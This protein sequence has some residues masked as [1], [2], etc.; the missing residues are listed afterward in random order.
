MGF[1]SR[2]FEIWG[3]EDNPQNYSNKA[4]DLHTN[5][6][7]FSLLSK[8]IN[9]AYNK[10][11]ISPLGYELWQYLGVLLNTNSTYNVAFS[12]MDQKHRQFPH[13]LVVHLGS[14][15]AKLNIDS[16]MI[17]AG[18]EE[19]LIQCKKSAFI[20]PLNDVTAYAEYL[21]MSYPNAKEFHVTRKPLDLH[22]LAWTFETNT[23]HKVVRQFVALM[24]MGTYHKIVEIEYRN[25]FKKD[26]KL[27]KTIAKK[28][29]PEWRQD[30]TEPVNKLQLNGSIQTVFIF[31]GCGKLFASCI[32]LLEVFCS[33]LFGIC[34]RKTSKSTLVRI[35]K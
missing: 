13:N 5:S 14:D 17:V 35:F 2:L 11:L 20:A 25:R 32:L 21:R 23:Q 3:I 9:S 15:T 29:L 10:I 16:K 34:F 27:I 26:A 18:I 12:L 33:F 8:R 1:S 19:E 31:W 24:E 7:C 30:A 4:R 28:V 6:K 22:Y